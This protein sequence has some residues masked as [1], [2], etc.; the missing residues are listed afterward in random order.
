MY[1]ILARGSVIFMDKEKLI[2]D[3]D[4]IWIFH[5]KTGEYDG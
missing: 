5:L 2:K 3:I 4:K 1:C